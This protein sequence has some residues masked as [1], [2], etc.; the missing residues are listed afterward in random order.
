MW[1]VEKEYVRVGRAA[2]SRNM[3]HEPFPVA[4]P[5]LDLFARPRPPQQFIDAAVKSNPGNRSYEPYHYESGELIG[6]MPDFAKG[7][8]QVSAA[9]YCLVIHHYGCTPPPPLR[10]PQRPH[11]PSCRWGL[12]EWP[13]PRTV[14]PDHRTRSTKAAARQSR[15]RRWSAKQAVTHL[16]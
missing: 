8:R 3:N 12:A 11:A 14:P 10:C 1:E 7:L 13:L 4:P 5:P 6:P 16:T 15:H 2:A 9:C